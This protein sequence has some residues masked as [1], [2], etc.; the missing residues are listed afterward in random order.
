M[1]SPFLTGIN[2]SSPTKY[3]GP[4]VGLV[5]IVTRTREP[6]TADYRQPETG[7]L[8]PFGQLWLVGENPTT[9]T[10][11]ELWYLEYIEANQ[12]IWTKFIETPTT[13]DVWTP[14][15]E[16][17][18]T[19]GTTTYSLQQGNYFLTD[20]IVTIQFHI[21]VTA[22]TGTGN[23]VISNLPF[24]IDDTAGYAPIGSCFTNG[25]SLAYP[26]GITSMCL[27]GVPNSKTLYFLGSG[28]S[29]TAAFL[30]MSNSVFTLGGTLTY[31]ILL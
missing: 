28:S 20:D 8:Y 18:S 29:A 26:A 13:S 22:A 9:G 2:P 31:K 11:G 19:A 4:N 25:A 27:D 10:R 23:L 30:Q 21:G 16:G 12:G 17:L 15:L 7:K 14:T 1:S 5:G 6:T 3:R 24:T